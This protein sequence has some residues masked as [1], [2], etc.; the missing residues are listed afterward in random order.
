MIP[1]EMGLSPLV[2][3]LQS[4]QISIA[5]SLAH[6]LKNVWKIFDERV[7]VR[8][9]RRQNREKS[10][11]FFYYGDY[12]LFPVDSPAQIIQNYAIFDVLPIFAVTSAAQLS[13]CSEKFLGLIEKLFYV[14]KMP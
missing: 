1:P 7:K 8:Q 4:L 3:L 9:L 6:R 10:D 13:G 5:V 14:Q 12:F 2:G 11:F